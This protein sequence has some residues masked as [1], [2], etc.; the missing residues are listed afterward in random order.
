M[1]VWIIRVR[2]PITQGTFPEECLFLRNGGKYKLHKI[3][4]HEGGLKLSYIV[5]K[6]VFE[7]DL[8]TIMKYIIVSIDNQWRTLVKEGLQDTG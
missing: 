5:T 3:D 1:F 4:W 8:N 6:N 7:N 2:I